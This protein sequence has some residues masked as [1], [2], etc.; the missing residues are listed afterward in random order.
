MARAESTVQIA[1]CFFY[2]Q[3]FQPDKKEAG[4]NPC[5]WW[6]MRMR[7]HEPHKTG[8]GRSR[9]GGEMSVTFVNNSDE[10]LR[11]LGEACERGLERCGEKAVEYAKDLCPVDTGN[12]RNTITHTV[13]D[14]KK[15]IVGTP[16]EYAIYQEMG[17]GKYA[18]GGGGRP[19]PWKY[20][21]AQGIW[22]WTAG[23]RAHPFIKPSIADH[24]GTY[25]NILKD[26]L[27]KG[28]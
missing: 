3:I 11:A 7:R 12:L 27:S 14:G 18:E 25:K 2:A 20:Q 5:L 26:E 6:I 17:T 13:E 28:D 22:H 15:A 8:S 23:N 1:W 4:W 21:D 16:T 10:T 9:K 19:T 24:Q